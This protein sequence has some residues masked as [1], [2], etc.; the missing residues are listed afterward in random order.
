ML[1]P[2]HD[3]HSA[4]PFVDRGRAP[5]GIKQR[6]QAPQLPGCLNSDPRL[7][8]SVRLRQRLPCVRYSHQLSRRLACD[9]GTLKDTG[10]APVNLMPVSPSRLAASSGSTPARMATPRASNFAFNS[11]ASAPTVG[12]EPLASSPN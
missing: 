1:P 3:C 2:E 4:Q 8:Q 12:C 9:S 10:T 7:L 5:L 11:S 6:P